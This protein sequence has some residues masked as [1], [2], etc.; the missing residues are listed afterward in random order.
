MG[1]ASHCDIILCCD[2]EGTHRELHDMWQAIEDVGVAANFFFVG[3]TVNE[4]PDL[5]REIGTN[6][7]TES[8][9]MHHLNLRK[10]NYYEQRRAI[11]DGKQTVED[12]IERP[13]RGFRA[14]YHSV[15]WD[16]MRILNEENFT[17]DASLLYY[18]YLSLGKVEMIR[19]TWFREW[20][21]LYRTLGMTPWRAFNI[22][23]FLVKR[24]NTCVLPAHPQYSGQHRYLVE[25][26]RGF[27]Q[28]AV[29]EGATFWP[30]DSYLQAKRGVPMPE[31]S[32][33]YAPTIEEQKSKSLEL[34]TTP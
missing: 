15:N 5:I 14:P 21:P 4:F 8:H 29:D 33:I 11:M 20:M 31:W 32:S 10:L 28:W 13:T 16:T 12:C 18:R 27:L 30:I 3:D 17:F 2:C 7:Q 24:T 1:L 25:A 9:T 34:K 6:H 26:F 23:R 22:F 19:P